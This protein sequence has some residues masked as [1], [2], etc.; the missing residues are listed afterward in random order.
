[1]TEIEIMIVG[2]NHDTAPLEVREKVAFDRA[3]LADALDRLARLP[4]VREGVILSTCNRVEVV[5][6]AA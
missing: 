4:S 5:A 3:S 1:M 6:A 2:L